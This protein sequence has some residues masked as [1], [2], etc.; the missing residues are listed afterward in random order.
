MLTKQQ[1]RIF[2]LI[3]FILIVGI[4][5]TFYRIYFKTSGIEFE[6][7]GN[8]NSSNS[9]ILEVVNQ[10][11]TIHIGGA[12][13]NPG[14]YA[15]SGN[16]RVIDVIR[17]AGGPLQNSDLDK[18]NLASHV[19]DGKKIIVPAKKNIAYSTQRKKNKS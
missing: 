3:I 12:I 15:V 2:F 10:K 8:F 19:K 13:K 9:E 16:A 6:E 7:T 1:K 11:V 4:L 18:I 17:L 14:I 5:V